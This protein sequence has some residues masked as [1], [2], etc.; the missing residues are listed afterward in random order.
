MFR[1]SCYS[2]YINRIK[3][4]TALW[5]SPSQVFRQI[6]QLCRLCWSAS[7][8]GTQR[9][10]QK[11]RP[12]LEHLLHPQPSQV[13]RWK[14][15]Q[16]LLGVRQWSAQRYNTYCRH[17]H[18]FSCWSLYC[19]YIILICLYSAGHYAYCTS[20]SLFWMFLVICLL[21]TFGPLLFIELKDSLFCTRYL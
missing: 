10:T 4:T 13:Q 14:E 15:V 3:V 18:T 20:Y 8:P 12:L 19:M 6:V 11:S 1:W 21:S 2:M 17:T 5:V 16:H 7:H 9:S